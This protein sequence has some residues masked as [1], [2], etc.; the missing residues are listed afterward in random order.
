MLDLNK[1]NQWCDQ[2]MSG[3]LLDTYEPFDGYLDDTVQIQTNYSSVGAFSLTNI[4]VGNLK[5][6]T[7]TN[8][9]SPDSCAILRVPISY[10]EILNLQTSHNLFNY[11]MFNLINK[12]LGALI[13]KY[14]SLNGLKVVTERPSRKGIYLQE[15]ENSAAIELRFYVENV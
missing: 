2:I 12:S 10:K 15:L 3:N 7:N 1:L 8:S 14:G 13:R 6:V 4:T 11:H 9:P 5:T